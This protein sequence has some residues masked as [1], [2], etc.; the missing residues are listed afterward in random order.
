MNRCLCLCLLWLACGSADP[1]P[2]IDL[3]LTGM[4]PGA[5]ALAL[6]GGLEGQPQ[7]EL[8]RMEV[9][10]H[11]LLRLPLGTTG[12][13][14]LEVA[15][16]GGDGC[17][18]AEGRGRA[19]VAPDT[20]AS[21][22]IALAAIAP[23]CAVSVAL[24]GAASGRVTSVPAGIDCPGTCATRFPLGADVTLSAAPASDAHF[25][26]FGGACAGARC[27]VRQ[28]V[29]RAAVTATFVP[30]L[31]MGARFCWEN[32]L[33][34]GN[35]LYGVLGVADER[36]AVGQDST[37]L[38]RV[39]GRWSRV[40][41]PA[42]VPKEM[43]SPSLYG[44]AGSGPRQ[45]WLVG[46]GG[47]I[48]AWDGTALNPQVSGTIADLRGVVAPSPTDAFA[49]GENGTLLR[50]QSRWLPFPANPMDTRGLNRVVQARGGELFAVGESGALL[51]L[52]VG[53]MAFQVLPAP[54]PR[55]LN[56]L[57]A[58]GD[59]G[60]FF[61][62]DFGLAFQRPPQG[63]PQAVTGVSEDILRA[64][65]VVSAGTA[66][67]LGDTGEL[68][69]RDAGRLV[70]AQPA[71]ATGLRDLWAGPAGDLWATGD[72]G[73]ILRGDAAG[74]AFDGAL[75]DPAD[76]A[77][78]SP[79]QALYGVHG[80]SAAAIYAVG[81]QGVIL[82]WDGERWRREVN[83]DRQKSAL[84]AVW[85]SPREV[86]AVGDSG[87]VL[88][89]GSDG[90]WVQLRIATTAQLNA[91]TGGEVQLVLAGR[92]GAL[93]RRRLV[94]AGAD[95]QTPFV[96]LSFATTELNAVTIDRGRIYLGGRRAA[97]NSPNLFVST[98]GEQGLAFDPMPT[99]PE[100]TQIRAIHFP[101]PGAGWASGAGGILQLVNGAWILAQQ[102]NDIQVA[103][104]GSPVGDAVWFIS[105]SGKILQY[106][107]KQIMPEVTGST[108][109]L[110]GVWGAAPDNF[111]VV[112]DDGAI[113]RFSP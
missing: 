113:L 77:S 28:L 40:A 56:G 76:A 5:V 99:P 6:R 39:G 96:E 73:A 83:P 55:T 11:V 58:D 30:G 10:D 49:V 93:Y 8:L 29:G 36:W 2:L 38:R 4:P 74:L 23:R 91:V 112:G 46:Q 12:P 22:E 94:Q 21:L 101:R 54:T 42:P 43:P 35:R 31:C 33:P 69:R 7:S 98:D 90:A 103:L 16:E 37:V 62:G 75:L 68:L 89:R 63:S 79:R 52:A 67:A 25:V 15:T 109:A 65:A 88:Q 45:L 17:E 60:V 95:E 50:Y 57:A 3:R 19:Q 84:R 41:V 72:G 32:P 82:R 13:F 51:R 48:L 87:T 80:W 81:A 18:R 107:N 85:A 53:G 64:A 9:P 71:L 14:V 106:A 20:C 78:L 97:A 102:T 26:G 105:N 111:L 24:R 100:V 86:Y 47:T 70:S 59:G 66:Y 104:W 34:Q 44:I 61:V 1:R 110:W 108:R 27:T 92:G